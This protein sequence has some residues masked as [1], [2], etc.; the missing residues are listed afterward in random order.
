MEFAFLS[1]SVYDYAKAD[2]SRKAE[3]A[4]F[5]YSIGLALSVYHKSEQYSI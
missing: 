4:P 1:N 5:I 2:H 3:I